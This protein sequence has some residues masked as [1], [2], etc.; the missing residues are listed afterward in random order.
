MQLF[1]Y[2]DSV[3]SWRNSSVYN[4]IWSSRVPYCSQ[5]PN[6]GDSQPALRAL[7]PLTSMGTW[8]G[9]A[10]SSHININVFLNTQNG[11]RLNFLSEICGGLNPHTNLLKQLQDTQPKIYNRNE[12]LGIIMASKSIWEIITGVQNLQTEN[13]V[14][15]GLGSSRMEMF[16][17]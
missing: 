14:F 17:H 6:L 15:W 1:K 3:T 10:Y 16:V 8:A 7:T 12:I 2:K 9:V 5:Q 13:N 4:S 11:K